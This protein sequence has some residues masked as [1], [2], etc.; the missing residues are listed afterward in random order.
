[1]SRSSI[2]AGVGESNFEEFCQSLPKILHDKIE[3]GPLKKIN[4]KNNNNDW[5][6]ILNNNDSNVVV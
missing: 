4:Y 6:Y 2:F 5:Q 3:K 1:M